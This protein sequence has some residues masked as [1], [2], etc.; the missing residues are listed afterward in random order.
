MTLEHV[1][2]LAPEKDLV[3]AEFV[4]EVDGVIEGARFA[5]SLIES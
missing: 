4:T 3:F 5:V 2:S 1:P